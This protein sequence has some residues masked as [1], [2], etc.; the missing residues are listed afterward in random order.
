MVMHRSPN[1]VFQAVQEQS[2]LWATP[3]DVDF[4]HFTDL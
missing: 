2:F 3:F 4:V 1:Q